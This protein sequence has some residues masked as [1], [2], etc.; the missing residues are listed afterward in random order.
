M[1]ST[2]SKTS[3]QPA[4]SH[5][6]TLDL[7]YVALFTVLMAVGSWISIPMPAPLVEFTMQTFAVCAALVILGG[8]RGTYAI[9]AYLLLGAVGAPVFAGFHGGLGVMLG[10]TGGYIVGFLAQA[11][12]Y[13]V[14]TARLGESLPVKAFA[15][16]VGIA[17][18]YAFGTAWFV[19]VYVQ[20]TGPISVLTALGYCVFP[21][22]LPDLL[23]MALA[24]AISKRVERCLK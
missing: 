15:C 24:L 6:R 16:V 2:T 18:L 3:P 12:L 4:A 9:I 8:R 1:T 21:F 14:I 23:K 5:L 19:A 7:T 17:V 10:S 11:V 13:W 22:I 20:T